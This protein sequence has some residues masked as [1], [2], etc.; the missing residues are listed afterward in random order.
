MVDWRFLRNFSEGKRELRL[1]FDRRPQN[2]VNRRLHWAT[3]AQPSQLR[4]F[5][6]FGQNDSLS[7]DGDEDFRVYLYTFEHQDAWVRLNAVGEPVSGG[8][9]SMGLPVRAS[10]ILFA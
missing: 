7:G 6:Q 9:G 3:L 10:S 5:N 1:I 4:C 8:W 2:S